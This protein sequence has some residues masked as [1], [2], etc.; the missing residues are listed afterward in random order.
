MGTYFEDDRPSSRGTSGRLYRPG[1]MPPL[2]GDTAAVL[3]VDDDEQLTEFLR[4]LL[5]RE[6]YR[7]T[8]ASSATSARARLAEHDFAI[9]L[10]DIKMPGENGLDL[11]ADL[12]DKYPTV[13]VVMMTVVSDARV[14]E[15]ALESGVYGYLVKPFQ[16]GQVLITVANAGRRR[17]LEIERSLYERSLEVRLDEQAA[18]LDDAL[19]QLKEA[20]P[21]RRVLPEFEGR[22][23]GLLEAA[24]DAIVAVDA[25][26]RIALVNAQAE[27]LFGYSRQELVGEAVELLVPEAARDVHPARRSSYFA[28]PTHRPMG[29]GMQLVGRRKDGSEFPAEISLSALETEE[30]LLVSAA[31][32]DVSE[33]IEAQSER[34]RLEARA[35]RERLE[36]QL[37][38]SQRLESLGQLAGGVAHDFNN[39]L[40]AIMNYASFVGEEIAAAAATGLTRDWA[41]V[42]RDVL[43]IQRA[44]ERGAQL[45]HQLLAFARREVVRPQVLV[46]NDVVGDVEQLLRRS[47]GEHVELVT[48]L[49][50][51]LSPVLADRGQMEQV[52]VNLAVNARDAMPSGGTLTIETENVL[53]DEGSA[54]KVPGSRAGGHVRLQMSDTGVGMDAGVLSRAFEPFFT[55]KPKGQGSGLGLATVYGIITQAGGVADIRSEPGRGMTFTALLPATEE[56][57]RVPEQAGQKRETGGGETVLVVEDEEGV[58]DVTE[59][60]LSHNGYAVLTAPNG[61]AAIDLVRDH[62]GWIDLLLTD[63]V[64]PQMLGKELAER[65]RELRPG[66]RVVFMSGYAEPV[67]GSQ[68][69]LEEGLTLVEKP[70]S[71]ATLLAQVKEALDGPPSPPAGPESDRRGG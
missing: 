66:I 36:S 15:T 20:T 38:Q 65:V 46:L 63:V 6:G 57:G 17:C 24:P 31:V 59:R 64:M 43:Q 29:A 8:V 53:L 62:Y 40:G 18:D 50:P 2:Y 5:E 33:R 60:I 21:Q 26:G 54:A 19:R 3:I 37:H 1:D 11:V 32:R 27:R 9:V 58:R 61:P 12:L 52:L 42:E 30:G 41:T 48:S 10:V 55:T 22:F 14:A 71:A 7:C 13:A 39:V 47:I 44:A 23:V 68:R 70:F 16:P 69:T 35:E 56:P 49:A 25:A 28:R 34:E 67:L 45:T 51:D 4:R